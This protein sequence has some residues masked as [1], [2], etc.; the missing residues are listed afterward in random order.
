[1]ANVGY[2]APNNKIAII[3][4]RVDNGNNT[5][6]II[7][8][9]TSFGMEENDMFYPENNTTPL[10][11]IENYE[12]IK[13]PDIKEFYFFARNVDDLKAIYN[14]DKEDMLPVLYF[15][16]V[17]ER[18]ILA[19]DYD[20][21]VQVVSDRLDNFM[22]DL[23]VEHK[24]AVKGADIT[25][26]TS[27][28]SYPGVITKPHEKVDL[29]HIDN[30]EMEN[31]LK[32]R[33]FEN[34]DNIEDIV[35]SIARNY[36]ATNPKLIK[37][38][39][40]IGPTGSGKSETYKLI[41]EYLGVPFTEYDCNSLTSAGF[42]GKDIEDIMRR[43][44]N[45]SNGDIATAEKS[46]IVIDE[47][48]KIAKRG[49]D[50]KE[51]KV[52][53]AFLKFFE[54]TI[55]DV[56]FGTSGS[57]TIKMNTSFMTKVACGA[58]PE[59]FEQKNKVIGFE[60]PDQTIQEEQKKITKKDIIDYGFIAELIGRL[61]GGL[62]VY[63]ELSSDIMKRILV[64]SKNSQLFLTKIFFDELYNA[65]LTWDPSYL[66]AVIEEAFKKKTGGRGL[67]EVVNE[68]VVKC[69]RELIH[70]CATEG[71]KRRVLKLTGNT[72]YDHKDF[73]IL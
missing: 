23:F 50:V 40:S 66:D 28:K 54:G 20:G 24:E 47:F 53:Q 52:Q 21:Y 29:A 65:E 5:Y 57:K 67:M 60:S 48:D 9:S 16:D 41:A 34:D 39:L 14:T 35:T 36:K 27:S 31:Y 70:L 71:N 63:K 15:S 11:S 18:V 30:F 56:S 19:L 73:T 61:N 43:I 59:L 64:D 49:S 44:Y 12:S 37:S 10:H 17:K 68:S 25:S 38:M 45:N 4:T 58:Y 46:I 72:V 13:N 3:C 42:V 69:D 33:I 1:M 7:P 26:Q 8:Q 62:F 55:Y 51:D 32:E 6:T 2:S 22:G